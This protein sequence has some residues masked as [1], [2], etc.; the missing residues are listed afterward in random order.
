MAGDYNSEDEAYFQKEQ[1]AQLDQVIEQAVQAAAKGENVEQL[2]EVML[3]SVS[4]KL[5]DVLKQ[6]FSAALKKRGLRQPSGEADIPSKSTLTRIRLALAISVK[7]AFER[8][9]L[10]VRA[11]PD[12]ANAIKQ[13]GQTLARNGVTVER[14]QISEAELGNLSAVTTAKSQQRNDT[15][16]GV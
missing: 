3:S 6:K 8:V 7:Q 11:R 13:A 1:E 16:R 4:G 12:V 14:I 9:L 10:L 5:R 2:L 15:G